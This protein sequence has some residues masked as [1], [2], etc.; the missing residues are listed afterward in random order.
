M[1][2]LM[3]IRRRY[4]DSKPLKGVR[5]DVPLWCACSLQNGA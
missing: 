5:V 3:S 2:G 1:L 4:A